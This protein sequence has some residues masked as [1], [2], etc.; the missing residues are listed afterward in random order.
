M[1][2]IGIT[3][4]PIVDTM[5]QTSTP[6]GLWFA[7]YFFSSVTRDICLK[8]QE[9][10]GYKILSLPMEKSTESTDMFNKPFSVNNHINENIGI[11]T[12]HDRVYIKTEKEWNEA[13]LVVDSAIHTAIVNRAEELSKCC[14]PNY[15]SDRKSIT[16]ALT[17]FLE[18]RYICLAENDVGEKGIVGSLA[19]TLDALELS[20]KTI[21]DPENNPLYKVIRGDESS[22]NIYLKKIPVLEE[23]IETNCR[24]FLLAQKSNNREKKS[25]IQIHDLKWIASR[26]KPDDI[27]NKKTANYFAI[28]QCD[29][30]N[31]GAIGK[32]ESDGEGCG[33][34]GK[35][36]SNL[37][38]EY[39][40]RS[41]ELI[42][43][44]GGVVI[45][46]GGD[47]LLFLAP[48][49]GNN[50]LYD[51]NKDK[52]DKTNSP[53]EEKENDH[54]KK[55]ITVW[56]LCQII[57]EKFDKTFKAIYDNGALGIKE[58]EAK[59][60]LS[61]GVSINYNKYPL[62]EAFADAMYLLFD[63][64]KKY[65]DNREK[66]KLKNNIALKVHKSSGQTAGF[67]CCMNTNKDAG[68]ASVFTEFI[69]FV[70]DYFMVNGTDV[71]K[72]DAI[73]E[74]NN[75]DKDTQE[76]KKNK[77]M[78]SLLYHM[79]SMSP[80][81]QRA[82]SDESYA[83]NAFSHAFDNDLQVFGKEMVD[84]VIDLS[85]KVHTAVEKKLIKGLKKDKDEEPDVTV[86]TSMLRVAKFLL[87]D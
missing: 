16:N 86:L 30:D 25:D 71:G 38:T 11:G 2:Y 26:G 53:V 1:N 85:I 37:C 6:A 49:I 82:L 65:C 81:F 3:I 72:A 39:T 44:F 75:R 5:M 34:K 68:S 19:E 78:H 57:S 43:K 61:F 22:S 73:K 10:E 62:Y 23:A 84:K 52:N 17:D 24:H 70:N 48:V 21:K 32:K 7:S 15:G 87:E 41:V 12:Y 56:E 67:V 28:V 50:P 33:N 51:D 40:S 14:L 76:D 45:Y 77:V 35:N 54:E 47:D 64:A 83:R 60:A 58:E 46:A 66:E 8:T 13:K 74:K 69:T 9:N 59:P 80:L 27:S 20:S 31:M 29:G 79:E 4:G 36:F 42:A 55:E 18:I 63:V